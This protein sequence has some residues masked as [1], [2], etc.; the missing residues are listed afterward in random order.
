[1]EHN[2]ILNEI[3]HFTRLFFRIYE[4]TNAGVTHRAELIGFSSPVFISNLESGA[5]APAPALVPA[6]APAPAPQPT[7][8]AAPAP[9]NV[10][11]T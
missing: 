1:M 6:P 5:P 2:L 11:V 7:Q 4:A 8:E 3:Y 9:E 10:P